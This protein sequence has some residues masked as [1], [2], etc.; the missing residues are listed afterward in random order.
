MHSSINTSKAAT[1][2]IKAQGLSGTRPP[3]PNTGIWIRPLNNLWRLNIFLY[4]NNSSYVDFHG[5]FII[6]TIMAYRRRATSQIKRIKQ[7]F[8]F[9]ANHTLSFSSLL[10]MEK[11]GQWIYETYTSKSTSY[12]THPNFWSVNYIGTTWTSFW[13]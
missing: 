8:H 6:L 11:I 3:R 1:G 7:A 2:S 13:F 4:I 10:V 12:S 5:L 9:Y